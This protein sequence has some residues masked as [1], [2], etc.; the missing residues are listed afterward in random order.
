MKWYKYCAGAVALVLIIGG[1][2]LLGRHAETLIETEADAIEKPE[3]PEDLSGW[4][5]DEE[6]WHYTDKEGNQVLEQWLE[7][8]EQT[9]YLN[10]SGAM[11][12]GWSKVGDDWYYM[13]PAGREETG[14]LA[15]GDKW[16]YLYPDSGIMATGWLNPG[17]GWYHLNG[18][19][20]METGWINLEEKTYYLNPDGLMQ[21]G[22][23][24]DREKKYYLTGEGH[25]QT[26]WAQLDGKTYYFQTD[27]AMVTGLQSLEG[28]TYC[29]DAE[30]VR[31]N[32]WITLD[33]NW[34]YFN[35]DGTM[36]TGWF[37]SDGK[38]YFMDN[39][40]M[41]RKGWLQLDGKS[42]YFDGNGVYQPGAVLPS[43]TGGPMIALTFDDGPGKYTDRLL[44]ALETNHVKATFFM[45]GNLVSS[46]PNEVRR[47]KSL[48]CEIGNHS[49]DHARLTSLDAAGVQAEIN[50]A[51]DSLR[52]VI[53]EGA[54][55]V[56]PPYG[57][58]NDM[59]KQN[60][61]LP[62]VLWSIDTLDWKTLDV[63]AT[64]DAVLNQAKDGDIILM[65]DI[66]ETSV[67]A[68]EA[69][70][71]ELIQRGFQMV[72]VSELAAAKGKN[73]TAGGAVGS[74]R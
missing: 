36:H 66:H 59:V 50:N 74:I 52:S 6:G 15:D 17:D 44:T 39:S 29:F 21:T 4:T 20:A 41:M 46:Y 31:Q 14:W 45:L 71:P 69:L 35:D 61:G 11:S 70:I 48:G 63:Q 49:Y 26:G 18:D 72:T 23:L 2:Y 32:G 25:M 55:V 12:T 42:V 1:L 28:A 7:L 67:A 16:Y 5:V 68:A 27:G 73:L 43:S 62:L 37:E 30:G 58:Y 65:H 53:G 38:K 64:V 9:Y 51:N 8:G 57:A 56:R 24:T 19:G 22:W 34:Y 33:N 60:A 47:M 40:G 10:D 3:E 13:D 54:T